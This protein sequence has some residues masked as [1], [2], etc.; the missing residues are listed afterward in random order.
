M[1]ALKVL[2]D[3]KMEESKLTSLK[4]QYKETREHFDYLYS[5][6]QKVLDSMKEKQ[7]GSLLAVQKLTSEMHKRDEAIMKV[8]PNV[9]ESLNSLLTKVKSNSDKLDSLQVDLKTKANKKD[10]ENQLQGKLDTAE[11]RNLAP[12]GTTPRE[13]FSELMAEAIKKNGDGIQHTI[14]IWDQKLAQFRSDVNI[15]HLLKRMSELAS[16]KSLEQAVE[17]FKED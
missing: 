1:T 2:V 4:E 13:F 14:K 11:F 5:T 7:K 3:A 8:P 6:Q 15:A 10:I 12:D 16:A 9:S 17:S